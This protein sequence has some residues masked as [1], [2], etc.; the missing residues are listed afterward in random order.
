MENAKKRFSAAIAFAL[1]LTIAATFIT[2]ASVTGLYL[3]KKHDAYV[4]VIPNP[5]GIGQRVYIA[6]WVTPPPVWFTGIVESHYYNYTFTITRPDGTTETKW[7]NE[8]ESTAAK[9][10]N[11]VCDKVGTWKV[12]LSWPGDDEW[13]PNNRHEGSVSAPAT[14]TVQQEPVPE[15][16][17]DTNPVPLP[18]G[19]WTYPISAEN[20]E[21]YQI[22][23]AWA[24][25][26][27]GSG[28]WRSAPTNF[29]PYSNGPYTAHILWKLKVS[30]S[31]LGGGTEG[32]KQR[33]ICL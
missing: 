22:S 28:G 27:Q 10:F 26:S 30:A 8:S 5:V 1:M 23:G 31:G 3:T 20:R 16:F 13:Y 11:Y 12:V 29:N 4:T 21:W 32:W 18:T 25:P 33:K 14:W 15:M 7:F 17:V 6:A 9:S 24:T 2:I 19:P